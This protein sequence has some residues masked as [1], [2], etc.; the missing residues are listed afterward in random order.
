MSKRF[1]KYFD[2]VTKIGHHIIEG[3]MIHRELTKRRDEQAAAAIAGRE[4]KNIMY[5]PLIYPS[6]SDTRHIINEATILDYPMHTQSSSIACHIQHFLANITVAEAHDAMRGITWVELYI[7][8]R[9]RGHPKSIPDPPNKAHRKAT[10]CKLIR[11]FTKQVR[12]TVART[13][14]EQ[15]AHLFKPLKK[16]RDALLG[17][18]IKGM[19]ASPCFN[20]GVSDEER[21]AIA[22]A[23]ISLSRSIRKSSCIHIHTLCYQ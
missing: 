15:D 12:G 20:V 10:A 7:L 5:E 8:Y 21:H 3:Y 16:S 4:A 22:N 14:L 17:V 19:H 13:L 11:S 23:L 2:L 6:M 9:I 18:G 1:D